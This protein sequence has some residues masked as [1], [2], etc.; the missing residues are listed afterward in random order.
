[1][2]QQPNL[3]KP[4]NHFQNHPT[5]SHYPNNLGFNGV[6]VGL[7]SNLPSN[8]GIGYN[9]NHNHFNVH[10]NVHIHYLNPQGSQQ[11]LNSYGHPMQGHNQQA[12]NGFHNVYHQQQMGM[13]G[14]QSLQ[15]ANYS[16]QPTF[17][18]WI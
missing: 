15:G 8:N 3:F 10:Q 18:N 6:G 12:Y 5:N 13:S 4:I 9:A 17:S 14:A 2:S 7:P 11:P 1:V 16:L